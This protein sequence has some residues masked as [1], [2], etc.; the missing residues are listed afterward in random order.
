MQMASAGGAAAPLGSRS[1]QAASATTI[2][3]LLVFTTLALSGHSWITSSWSAPGQEASITAAHTQQQHGPQGSRLLSTSR[4]GAGAAP[5]AM[6][7]DDRAQAV[8]GPQLL[9]GY[10]ATVLDTFPQIKQCGHDG[11]K[12]W[13]QEYAHLHAAATTATAAAVAAGDIG[14]AGQQRYLISVPHLSGTADHII[15]Q[16]AQFF[17]AVLGDRAFTEYSPPGR[18]PGLQAACDFPYFNWTHPQRLPAA[19]VEA[20]PQVATS[21]TNMQPNAAVRYSP[22][23]DDYAL[24][25]M[26]NPLD[27][28]LELLGRVN[29]TDF[30]QGM[31]DIP[32]VLSTSNRGAS[33][34]MLTNPYHKD[35]FWRQYGLR[36]ETA[37]MCGFWS[38]CS[39]N[40]AVQQMYG[41]RFWGRLQE[42]GVMRIGIQVRF[43]DKLAF[44]H[45][46]DMSPM[47]LLKLAAPYF[48]CARALEDA[49]AAPGQRVVWF[50]ISDSG[51]FR[52][53][54]VKRYG[55]KVLTDDQLQLVHVACHL[56]D[57]PSLCKDSTLQLAV[58]H[59]VGE[60][61]SF[62]LTDYHIITRSSGFGR[63]GAWLSGRWGNLYELTPGADD[64][65]EV[66]PGRPTSPAESAAHFSRM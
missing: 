32:A 5:A 62:S 8:P 58:Q 36:P 15:G 24:H 56:N 19:L 64:A 1:R 54:A 11:P 61:L 66:C 60:M 48:Q 3:L 45:Q 16:V 46:S 51:A 47:A 13:V 18:P 50:I 41:Q 2:G 12:E 25:N 55:D 6:P 29:L 31:A 30:P 17:L 40:A 34:M 7:A 10:P 49:Y 35:Q 9:G 43:G 23:L 44:L 39:P 42:P 53:A 4:P 37:F 26:V 28:Q 65:A 20:L 14:T 59:S 21:R 52:K 33:Y 22:P 63:V 38:L 57:D 27:K